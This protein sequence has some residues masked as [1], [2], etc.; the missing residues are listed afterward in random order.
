MAVFVQAPPPASGDAFAESSDASNTTLPYPIHPQFIPVLDAD[1]IE[2]HNTHFAPKPASHTID[3]AEIRK[4]QWKYASPWEKDFS[5]ETFVRDLQ[6]RS[7][8]EHIFNARCYY[9]DPAQFGPG[10]YPIHVNFHGKISW[11]N[12]TIL[13]TDLS[14]GGGYVFG[15]LKSD[16]EICMLVRNKVG[17]LVV[18]I[19]YRLTPGRQ[20]C[21]NLVFD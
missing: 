9:P 17:I 3:I 4:N 21:C 6:I 18:D 11:L 1:F 2:Y 10:P 5:H 12:L 20:P 14:T 13:E 7:L 19:E 15:G 16:A 8:D